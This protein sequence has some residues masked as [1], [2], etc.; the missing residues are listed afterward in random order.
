MEPTFIFVNES[1]GIIYVTGADSKDSS[2]FGNYFP[3]KI[4]QIP[5]LFIVKTKEEKGTEIFKFQN[6]YKIV[7]SET[8]YYL[9][10]EVKLDESIK[11]GEERFKEMSD[12]FICEF[13]YGTT[14]PRQILYRVESSDKKYYNSRYYFNFSEKG[15]L[16]YVEIEDYVEAIFV[17]NLIRHIA[18]EDPQVFNFV[19]IK[20]HAILFRRLHKLLHESNNFDM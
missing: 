8:E 19:Q 9:P 11:I 2:Y 1:G 3:L 15:M 14:I 7:A 17:T 6:G 12:N 5:K 18:C 20:K 16:E 10:S 4:T 13:H